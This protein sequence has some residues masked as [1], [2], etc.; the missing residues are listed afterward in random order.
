VRRSI[1]IVLPRLYERSPAYRGIITLVRY[2]AFVRAFLYLGVLGLVACTPTSTSPTPKPFDLRPYSSATPWV[3]P[4]PPQVLVVT[5]QPGQPT[6]TPFLYTIAAGDTLSQIAEKYRVS[7]DDLVSQNP[8]VD[9][10]ALPVGQTLKIPGHPEEIPVSASPTPEPLNVEQVGCHRV[11]DGGLWCFVLIRNEFSELI[12][13]VS[14]EVWLIGPEGQQLSSQMAVL[15]LDIL[16]PGQALP[17][18]AYFAPG[19]PEDATPQVQLL[20]AV[21]LLPDQARYLPARIEDALAQ[22]TWSGLMADL[23]G[24]VLLPPDAP[25]A[26]SVW[27]AAVAYDPQGNVVGLR[28]WSSG[29]GMEPGKSLGFSFTISAVSGRID[30]VD[31]AVEAIP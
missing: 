15:P 26:S 30:R 24:R 12:E 5:P 2:N 31:Y 11:A 6:A 25:S 19:I 28:R 21:R 17:L 14:A 9:P 13:D 22:V 18:A 20:T 3:T 8:N 23:T 1:E 4:T 16:P 29:S 7:L 10:S 27:V